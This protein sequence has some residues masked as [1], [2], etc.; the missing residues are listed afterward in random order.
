MFVAWFGYFWQ[1]FKAFLPLFIIALGG[2][3]T[4]FGWEE[5]KDTKGAFIDFSSPDEASR[6]Q[7]EALAYQEKIDKL[8]D[9]NEQPATGE[10]DLL[11]ESTETVT[12]VSAP[13]SSGDEKAVLEKSKV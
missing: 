7:A 10:A 5:R 13:E 3:L 4:Y 9:S 2:L 1:V 8:A 11:I 6:Y 12:V